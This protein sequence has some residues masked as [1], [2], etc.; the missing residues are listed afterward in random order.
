MANNAYIYNAAY[1]GAAGAIEAGRMIRSAVQADYD[2]VSDNAE[3]LA[4]AVD[5]LIATNASIGQAQGDLMLSCC[6]AV[7]FGRYSTAAANFA[8]IA[9]AI[10]ALYNATSGA[11]LAVNPDSSQATWFIDEATGNDNNK[12]DTAQTALRTVEAL[13]TRLKNL[14]LNQSTTIQAVGNLTQPFALLGVRMLGT[15][16]LTIRGTATAAGTG[17]ISNV[18]AIGA[19]TTFP[20]T[21]T[22]TGIVW[23]AG[24]VGKRLTTNTSKVFWVQEVID[25]NNVVLGPGYTL[26]GVGT[27]SNPVIAETFSLHTLS[28]VPMSTFQ[29]LGGQPDANATF[30]YVVTDFNFVDGDYGITVSGSGKTTFNG[31]KVTFPSA[32]SLHADNSLRTQWLA[33]HF[34]WTGTSIQNLRGIVQVNYTGCTFFSAANTQASFQIP[35]LAGFLTNCMFQKVGVF[36]S[37]F[38]RTIGTMFCRNYTA[39]D[40]INVQTGS[41]TVGGIIGG[42]GNTGGVGINVNAGAS[43]IYTSK[44]TI[45]GTA[46]DTRIGGTITAYASI[47]FINTA[48]NAT[49]ALL[50]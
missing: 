7:L 34:E 29:W 15:A 33:C 24:D 9:P 23:A 38:L 47:P 28:T 37:A 3:R 14:T 22:T 31:C 44:P 1:Q 46:G 26:T 30:N 20:W 40:V 43:L 18:V 6:L 11:L 42:S 45:T 8:T 12:G 16:V 4:I 48:N 41:F 25:A 13:N 17:T 49:M 2:D 39:G 19:G 21:V 50:A 5:A 35:G 10:V 36:T 27:L 32:T